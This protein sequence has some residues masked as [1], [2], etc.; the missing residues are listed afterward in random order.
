M[1]AASGTSKASTPSTPT[2][3]VSPKSTSVSSTVAEAR[4]AQGDLL[5][6]VQLDGPDGYDF[7]FRILAWGAMTAAEQGLAG[8]GALGPVSAFGLEQLVEGAASAGLSPVE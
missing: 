6:S 1:G 4:S 5:H 8:T 7:T 3:D 2:F